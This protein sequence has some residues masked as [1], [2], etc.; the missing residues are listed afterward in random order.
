M[1]VYKVDFVDYKAQKR[2]NNFIWN[3]SELKY[4]VEKKRV[5]GIK[6]HSKK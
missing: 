1:P 3:K 6:D 5:P 2:I 4:W